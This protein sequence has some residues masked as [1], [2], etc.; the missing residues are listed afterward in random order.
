VNVGEPTACPFGAG[1]AAVEV[2]VGSR[3]HHNSRRESRKDWQ[4]PTDDTATEHGKAVHRAKGDSWTKR[5]SNEQGG[6]VNV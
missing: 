2:V 5:N 4:Q 1:L 3:S 6:F